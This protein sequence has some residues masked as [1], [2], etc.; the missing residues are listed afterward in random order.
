M[1]RRDLS[2]AFVQSGMIYAN[3]S[4]ISESG[5]KM[6]ENCLRLVSYAKCLSIRILLSASR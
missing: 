1:R 2:Y 3:Y 4:V 6:Q 5:C